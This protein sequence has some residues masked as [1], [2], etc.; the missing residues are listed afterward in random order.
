MGWMLW[1]FCRSLGSTLHPRQK[2]KH[3]QLLWHWLPERPYPGAQ[4]QADAEVLL[5]AETEPA[6]QA[7]HGAGPNELL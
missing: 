6:G 4:T 5:A 3:T 1:C 2:M 7:V